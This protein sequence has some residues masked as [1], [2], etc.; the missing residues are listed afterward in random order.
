MNMR[1]PLGAVIV[2]VLI[3]AMAFPPLGMGQAAA[4]Q[5]AGEIARLIPSVD[6]ARGSQQMTAELKTPVDWGDVIETQPDGRARV[7]LDDGS[8]INVGADSTME[9][10][11]HNSAQQQSQIDL[12]YGRMRANVVKFTR[13]N[14][15]FEVHT[16]AGVAGVVGADVYFYYENDVFYVLDFEGLV[17]FCPVTGPCQDL[18]A[19]QIAMMRLGHSPDA[20]TE[21]TPE[22]IADAVSSTSLDDAGGNG[23]VIG[24][25]LT[26][27]EIITL[28]VLV[29]VPA[30]VLP[31]VLRGKPAT[32][33]GCPVG[34]FSSV[35]C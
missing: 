27:G 24:R 8:V 1:S 32:Q 12:T 13:P 31:I 23:P 6:I 30:I 25:H 11:Q 20:P 7:G 5:P 33:P 14:A 18:I 4:P 28:T 2:A 22:E 9:I 35:P 10:T 15:K 19:G 16:P 21:A 17:H 34:S 3:S 26:K 29:A